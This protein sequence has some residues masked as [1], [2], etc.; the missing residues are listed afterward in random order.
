MQILQPQ[1]RS[2]QC[3]PEETFNN[4]ALARTAARCGKAGAVGLSSNNTKSLLVLSSPS[5]QEL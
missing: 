3:P 2:L 5:E 4:T 1:V